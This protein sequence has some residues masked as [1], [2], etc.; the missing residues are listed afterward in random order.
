MENKPVFIISDSPE[1]KELFF[2]FEAYSK[3]ISELIAYKEN[4][5]P[6]V[7]G[8]FGKWGSGKTTL[9]KRVMSF[10]DDKVIDKDPRVYRKCKTVWFQPWKYDNEN[11]ILAALIEEIFKRMETD[12]FFS[13]V[14]GE[15]E[16][17]TKGIS[18]TKMLGKIS[19]L[20]FAGLNITD[21]FKDMEYK[22]KLGFYDTFNK[23]FDDLLW[24]YLNWRPKIKASEKPDDRN[25]ALVVFIDDLDRCPKPRI[26]KVLE[27]IK[28]FMDKEG[29]IFVIGAANE[30]IES[31]LE[32]CYKDDAAS[33][34]DKIVQVTFN[35]PH[36]HTDLFGSYI[37]AISQE[38]MGEISDYL[39]ILIPEIKHNP[40]QL[41]RILNDLSL[42]NG[43]LK[44]SNI[45]IDYHNVM[46]WK[47]IDINNKYLSLKIDLTENISN[48]SILRTK[49][50][51]IKDSAGRTEVWEISD[52]KL[53]FFKVPHSLRNYI[54]NKDVVRLIEKFSCD[55]K[56]LA[57]LMTIS[58]MVQSSVESVIKQK[59][60]KTVIDNDMV[61]IPKG[62]FLFG[63][64]KNPTEIERPY[65]IDIYPVTNEQYRYFIENDG[66]KNESL[67]SKD[68]WA[69]LSKGRITS[70]EYWNNEKFNKSDHPVVGVSYFEA[71]AYSKW[72]GKR[73]PTEEEWERAA[74]GTNG[75]IYPWGDDFDKDKC[76]SGLSGFESTSRVNLFTNGISEAGCYDMAGNVWEWTSSHYNRKKNSYVLRGG[77]WLLDDT[78]D[79]RCAFR[80]FRDPYG[81]DSLVGFR[82][83]RT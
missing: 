77:S 20:F 1:S 59:N 71:E 83:A 25:G 43:L 61:S 42:Q 15:F 35:L 36:I 57:Q 82:C 12:G 31:A 38:A 49:I 5:T 41:K 50:N 67:W 39:D 10:L 14:K 29:C 40:R 76:N 6:L 26:V 73:L 68:G 13:S 8:I 47:I 19:E 30:I 16:K 70:P 7:V 79:F 66:Y 69:W 4:K 9:M 62:S 53:E 17:L 32:E 34:M 48:F 37:G 27:T 64:K 11:E 28:L 44:N 33:F 54:K 55:E 2:G 65:E 52:D 23:F 21:F 58:R 45:E 56:Q 46:L 63:D 22:D 3:T 51:E 74:R 80:Y 75:P 81:R 72:A 78:D 18:K 24:T 60:L